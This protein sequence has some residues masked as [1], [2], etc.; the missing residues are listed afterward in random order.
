MTLT[1]ELLLTAYSQGIFPMAD[2]PGQISWYSPDPRAIL[3]L[4]RLHTSRS[5]ARYLHSGNF[6][7][8]F[9]SAF[10][11][12]ITAC[13]APGPGRE[14]T[15]IS[16]EIIEAYVWLH[17]LGFAHS[18]ETWVEG[19]L[20]G[21]LYGVSLRGLFAG[22]SMFSARPNASKV[23]LFYLVDRL[24]SQGF[25]LLDVQFLTPHLERMGA[26]E[27]SRG[28]YQK[29]LEQAMTIITRF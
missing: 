1:P 10:L 29:M 23:A 13:A 7:V 5:L 11:D 27:V 3:P 25:T 24:R 6:E 2:G 21:G 8:R 19:S 14:E 28:D 17:Q 22:E 15:W 12:V 18:V 9:N 16:D 20:V 4:D 26:I